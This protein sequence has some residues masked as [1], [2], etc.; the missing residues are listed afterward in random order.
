VL[1][2][3]L[4]VAACG[5]TAAED[6][7]VYTD[8]DDLTLFQLPE[9]WNLYGSTDLTGLESPFIR[10]FNGQ[11]PI[12]SSVAFDG[13]PGANVTNLAADLSVADYPV[14]AQ[15]VRSIG[16]N[17]RDDVSRTLLEQVTFSYSEATGAQEVVTEDFSFGDDYEGIRRLIGLS[18]ETGAS[19][20]VL[21]FISVTDPDDSLMYSMA[22]G[23]SFSCWEH[24]QE[25]IVEVVDSWLVNT[26]R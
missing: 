12:I 18:D 16:A 4:L 25:Q 1:A 19:R 11:L 10:Q 8:P 6:E 3:A 9:G 21:Y 26:N 23:C 17:D 7:L 2:I 14:G 20:G 24:Y 15:I 13:A 22:A 5:S